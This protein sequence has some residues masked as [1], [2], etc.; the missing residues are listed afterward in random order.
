MKPNPTGPNRLPKED[1]GCSKRAYHKPEL[2]VYGDMRDITLGPSLGGVEGSSIV[3]RR[4]PN[5]P[6]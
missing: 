3:N 1:G 2:Q 5:L 4:N 6:A